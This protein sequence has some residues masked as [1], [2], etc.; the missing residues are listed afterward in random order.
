MQHSYEAARERAGLT[1]EYFEAVRQTTKIGRRGKPMKPSA[2]SLESRL[3]TGSIK[4]RAEA[5]REWTASKEQRAAR[6]QRAEA[7][8]ARIASRIAEADHQIPK[9]TTD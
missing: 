2:G 1:A 9:P 6:T 8:A 4:E 3:V 5:A 7:R